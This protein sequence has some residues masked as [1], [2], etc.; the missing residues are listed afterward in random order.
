VRNRHSPAT[1]DQITNER[2]R[3]HDW[4]WRDHRHRHGIEKLSIV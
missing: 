4:T 1:A 3:D 2:D